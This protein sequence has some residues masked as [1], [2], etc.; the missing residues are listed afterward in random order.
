MNVMQMY[1]FFS[2]FQHREIMQVMENKFWLHL[3]KLSF[4]LKMQFWLSRNIVS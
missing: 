4:A 3:S 1:V 2:Y